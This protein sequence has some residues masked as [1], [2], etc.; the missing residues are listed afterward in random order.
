MRK[1]SIL[2]V[3]LL[4]MLSVFV[5]SCKPKD[6]KGLHDS[7]I[8]LDST[9]VALFFKTYPDLKEYQKELVA[10]Y[11]IYEYNYI[12]HDEKGIA[13]FA[14]S[15]Y[16]KVKDIEEE[17]ISA[18]F[19]YQS[20]IDDVFSDG[21]KNDLSSTDA[22]LMLTSLYLFYVDKVYKGI[23]H[24]ATT[25]IGWLLPRKKVSYTALLDLIISDDNFTVGDSLT[26][27]SQYFKLR[28][29]LKHYRQIEE[30][31]GWKPVN[32]DSDIKYYK[33]ND[34]AEAIVQIRE[35]LFITGDIQQNNLSNRY[36]A[37]LVAA[38]QKYQL[39][40]GFK[41]D[42]LITPDHIK[43]LNVPVGDRI[44][45]IVVNME[46][47][48][49]LSPET[50]LAPAYIFVNIPSYD[51]RLIRKGKTD[52]KSNVVVGKMMT[53]TVIFA[54]NMT[55]L[56]FS[57]YWNLPKN[58]IEEEVKPGLEKNKNYLKTHNMEWNNGQVRQLPGK[59]NSLGLVKFMFPNSNEIYL[60]DTPSK[61]LFSKEN[62]AFSH[63]C[64]RVSRARD[65]AIILLENNEDWN[66]EKIDKAM[67]A[68]KESIYSLKEKIPV[69]IGY[70]TAWV[71]DLGNI[72]FYED[73]YERDDRLAL[74][75]FYKE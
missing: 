50:F 38:V 36:D 33:P 41:P 66:E 46:R 44:K 29:V 47:C 11:Q 65:L 17:G 14:Y 43:H 7:S 40:N 32:I 12:W 8:S 55:Y 4:T 24:D 51:M 13:E 53:Q 37:D 52:F 49:W 18:A 45:S 69:H 71:D 57:P 56:V 62:R 27:Y 42:S 22:E 6:A 28:E 39:R 10:F 68:G 67:H 54:G 15:L 72:N 74:L 63:G 35:H 21:K 73:V 70:F 9:V 31:G 26:I 2:I 5:D 58:I 34:T 60:H 16:N 1:N 3:I 20:K 19:P 64:V 30:S 75:L 23:D 48:R 61:N 25:A 59:S